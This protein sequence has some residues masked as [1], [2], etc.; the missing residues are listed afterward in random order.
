MIGVIVNVV[1]IM[2]GSIIGLVLKKGLSKKVMLVVMQAIGL[3]VVVIGI[4]GAIKTESF[5]LI[6]ISLV[7]GGTIGVLIGIENGLERF[8]KKVEERFSA[9]E[10]NFAKGFVMATL[11]YCVGAMAIVGSIEAGVNHNYETLYI[12]SVLDGVTAIVFTA[13]LGY[14]VFFS[15]VSVLIYQ[16][17][18]VLLGTQLEPLLT[19]QIVTEMSAV[20]SVIIFGIGLN[21]LEIK[22]I[23]VGDLLPAVFIPPIWFFILSVV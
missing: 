9:S 20:G 11:I 19:E 3:S 2:V 13:T 16:G 21:L 6:V 15:G 1:A 8:G 22:T 10:G 12:K 4:A 5:L 18:I 14:G 7:L 23:R 17:T